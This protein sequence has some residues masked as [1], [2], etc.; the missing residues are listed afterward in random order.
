[1][2]ILLLRPYAT[3]AQG[4]TIDL[5][6]ATEAALVGQGRATYTVNP[7]SAFAPLTATEQ[8][9]TRDL[10][11]C[12]DSFLAWDDLRFP[13]QGINPAG[14]A[15]APAVDD[16]LTSFP[17]TLLFSGSQ[18]NIIAGVAQM[19]HAWLAGSA[20]R[21]HIHW[22]NPTGTAD[23]VEWEFWYRIAGYPGDVSGPLVGPVAGTLTAGS[24]AVSDQ[25]CLTSFGNIDMTGQRESSMMA[26]Q[27]RRLGSDASAGTARLFE[28]DIHYQ[29][30]KLGTAAEFP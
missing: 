1:M 20:I 27:I 13:A 25:H 17:G 4:S 24:P 6:N 28:F 26:W 29:I 16:V 12:N 18:D 8:Q 10:L 7:G 2:T 15:A 19:P 11:L 22:S 30:G 9:R 5:D 23:A 21:P 14:A 3:F